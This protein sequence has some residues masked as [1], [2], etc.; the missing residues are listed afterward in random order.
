MQH[1]NTVTVSL[2]LLCSLFWVLGE[3]APVTAAPPS[4]LS[5]A[6]YFGLVAKTE[7]ATNTSTGTILFVG[8]VLLA[9]DVEF[10]ITE[11]GEQYPYSRIQSFFDQHQYVLANFEAAVP[12]QHI[13]TPAETLSFS[14]AIDRL[15]AL[16]AAGVT[17]VSLANNHSL[18]KGVAG[19]AHTQQTLTQAGITS[20]GGNTITTD[21]VTYI[22]AGKHRVAVVGINVTDQ[23]FDPDPY[24][25]Q[26]EKSKA[27]SDL[28]IIYVHWGE[29]YAE[30]HNENQR[31]L[32]R[33]LVE[34]G[35][36]LVLGHHPHV[37]QDIEIYRDVPIIY[38]LGNFIFDQYFDEAVQ[39]GLVVTLDGTD[40]P[41]ISLNGVTS[42]DQPAAPRLL[43]GTDRTNFLQAVA[44]RSTST[45][46]KFI[47]A[48]TMTLP[49]SLANSPQID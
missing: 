39:T 32:A 6:A 10:K 7:P 12:K 35:A 38:S 9:R 4:N 31:V 8:D 22:Q 30:T 33:W 13:P 24:L 36:D 26:L 43:V 11:Y 15:P 47:E 29:E 19:Y 18:D 45:A 28:Q 27:A 48:G 17:H 49:V 40:I 34:S 37:V 14:V 1:S 25:E 44:A 16:A 46:T 41:F 21:S 5:A 20:F 23:T 42:T 2:G 3:V